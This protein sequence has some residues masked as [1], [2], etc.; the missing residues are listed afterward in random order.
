M[1]GWGGSLRGFDA[2][3]SFFP[4]FLH[5]ASFVRSFIENLDSPD[6]MDG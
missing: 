3:L 2:F 6:G 1:R 4:F 5:E